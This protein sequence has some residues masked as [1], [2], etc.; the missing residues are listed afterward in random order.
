MSGFTPGPW[1][2]ISDAGTYEVDADAGVLGCQPICRMGNVFTAKAANARLI[3]A[4]PDLYKALDET[5][6][7]MKAL[8][9]KWPPYTGGQNI[10]DRA[11]AALRKARGEARDDGERMRYAK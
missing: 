6:G 2:A 8:M 9:A 1:V 7:E 11:D 5:L 3:A 4:A 10:A